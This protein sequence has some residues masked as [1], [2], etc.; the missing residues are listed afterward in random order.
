MVLAERIAD[1]HHFLSDSNARRVGEAGRLKSAAGFVYLYERKVVGRIAADILDIRIDG[2]VMSDNADSLG[3]ARHMF[4]CHHVAVAT[5]NN[6]GAGAF[7]NRL[8]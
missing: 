1:R 6:A 5:D 4:V 7:G 2:A 8:V 3:I